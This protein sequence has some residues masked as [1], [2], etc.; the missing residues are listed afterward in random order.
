MAQ[1]DAFIAFLSSLNMDTGPIALLAAAVFGPPTLSNRR[2]RQIAAAAGHPIRHRLL[3]NAPPSLLLDALVIIWARTHGWSYGY[4]YILPWLRR[5]FPT[6]LFTWRDVLRSM[7]RLNPQAAA[8]RRQQALRQFVRAGR[9]PQ[10]RFGQY[11]QSDLNT[12]NEVY[13]VIIAIAVDVG[14]RTITVLKAL[15]VQRTAAALAAYRPRRLHCGAALS[16]RRT[17]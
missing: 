9:F 13:G 4:R 12:V 10:N 7:R 6:A 14:T 17:G 8:L 2:V 15:Q 16:P 5:I 3:R 11:V 1:R